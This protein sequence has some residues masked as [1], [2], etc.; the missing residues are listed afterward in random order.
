MTDNVV[1]GWRRFLDALCHP[2]PIFR[3][4]HCLTCTCYDDGA[5][6]TPPMPTGSFM[7]DDLPPIVGSKRLDS[8][9]DA[10]LA[11]RRES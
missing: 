7:V 10:F 4:R 11:R 5:A 8:T 3:R 2:P 9:P 6:R 1:S